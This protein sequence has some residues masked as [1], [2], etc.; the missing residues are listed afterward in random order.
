MYL[1]LLL[2]SHGKVR[3]I[4]LP[5]SDSNIGAYVEA[6]ITVPASSFRPLRV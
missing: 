4:L 3:N 6:I 2:L 5:E 1:K